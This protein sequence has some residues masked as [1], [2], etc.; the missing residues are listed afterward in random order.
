MEKKLN[1]KSKTNRF[2]HALFWSLLKK[3]PGYNEDYKDV[4]KEGVVGEYSSGK[5]DSLTELYQKY[6]G[7]YSRM[8]D[9]L[10][11]TVQGGKAALYDEE[12]DKMR[13]RVLAVICA[14]IEKK[15]YQFRSKE[16]KVEYAKRVACR[17]ANCIRFNAIPLSKLQAIY[18]DWVKKNDV[19]VNRVPELTHPI[20]EN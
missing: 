2:R 4:I 16:E 3:I 18:N 8:I 10:K 17:A 19:D 5:T 11:Q 7:D 13:K 9:G 15:K 6:P 1:R 12:S 14:G 20:S